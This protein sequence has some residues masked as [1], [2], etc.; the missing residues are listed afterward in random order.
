MLK[1]NSPLY[2]ALFNWL[3]QPEDW[4]HLSH[5]S[6]CIWL[7][8][9]LIHTGSVNLT[10]WVTHVPCRGVFAQSTQRRIGRW[11]YSP[12]INIHRLYKPL[13]QAAL[14]DWK[15]KEIFLALDTS[16][17]WDE[18]CLVAVRGMSWTRLARGVA[19]ACASQRECLL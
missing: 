12:R 6:T 5:L 16:L 1:K 11:L 14:A 2:H 7:V 17:F 10:K 8:I 13:I 18:Y 4:A 15:D 9:A 3:G 19:G